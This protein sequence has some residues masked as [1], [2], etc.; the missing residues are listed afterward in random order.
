VASLPYV[1]SGRL[2]GI[3][4]TGAVR[5]L[6]FPDIPTIAEAGYPGYEAGTWYALLAPAG[7]PRQAINRLNAEVL[8]IIQVP[9]LRERLADLGVEFVGSTPEA[10]IE[11]I[12]SELRKWSLVIKQSNIR[13]D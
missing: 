12:K 9:D 11:S 10:C 2:R 6:A 1:K 7:T 3:A 8:K 4:G 5:S 13:A